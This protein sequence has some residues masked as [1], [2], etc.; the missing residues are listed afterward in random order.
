MSQWDVPT[1]YRG[2]QYYSLSPDSLPT[3]LGINPLKSDFE[4]GEVLTRIQNPLIISRSTYALK[5]Y[6][7][8]IKDTWSVVKQSYMTQGGAPQLS[9]TDSAVFILDSSVYYGY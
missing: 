9:T 2:G 1:T 8:P 6:A 4:T 5:S 7:A 3:Q